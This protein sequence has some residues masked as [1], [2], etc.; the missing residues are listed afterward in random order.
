MRQ[1]DILIRL[2]EL[3]K[4]SKRIKEVLQLAILDYSALE[5][6]LSDLEVDM[7]ASEILIKLHNERK[8]KE[9]L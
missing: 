6:N 2:E 1:R 7:R 4:E 3:N 5:N 8:I 9:K